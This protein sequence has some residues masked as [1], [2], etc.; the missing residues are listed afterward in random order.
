VAYAELSQV[1]SLLAIIDTADDTRLTH[2][3]DVATN[4]IDIRDNR[5]FGFEYSSVT[6][7]FRLKKN[8]RKVKLNHTPVN[9]DT[10]VATLDGT[11]LTTD[12]YYINENTGVFELL[13]EPTTTATSA[14]ARPRLVISY[15]GGYEDIPPAIVEACVVKTAMLFCAGEKSWQERFQF[16]QEYIDALILPYRRNAT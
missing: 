16:N 7:N 3:S 4:Y 15:S 2:L 5:Y 13:A 11:A 14:Y 8:H 9:E 1:K 12:D 10:I 6:E